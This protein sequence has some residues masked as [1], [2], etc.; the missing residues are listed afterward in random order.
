[1]GASFALNY[2]T[3]SSP[4]DSHFNSLPSYGNWRLDFTSHLTN[5]YTLRCKTSGEITGVRLALRKGVNEMHKV[6]DNDI[7][8]DDVKRLKSQTQELLSGIQNKECDLTLSDLQR[9]LW[10]C[11]GILVASNKP[12][13]ELLNYLVS[14]PCRI[15]TSESIKCGSQ[16]WNWLY[17]ERPDLQVK[18]IMKLCSEWEVSI[19]N[20]KGLF[21]PNFITEDTFNKEIEYSPSD[22]KLSDILISMAKRNFEPHLLM[23]K[24]FDGLLMSINSSNQSLIL[25]LIKL[26]YN[27]NQLHSQMSNHTLS[28]QVRFSLI[29]LGF[30]VLNLTDIDSLIDNK[31][32]YSLYQTSFTW[33]NVIPQLN[34]GND[35]VEIESDII[36]LQ[37]IISL[38]K[39]DKINNS[40]NKKFNY[41]EQLIEFKNKSG[42]LT[43]LLE[44]EISR[45]S[46]WKNVLGEPS[47]GN[48]LISLSERNMNESLWLTYIHLSWKISPKLAIGL[49][50]RFKSTMIEKEVKK[51]LKLRPFDAIDIP[52]AID[53]LIGDKLNKDSK[54]CLNL[55]SY[56]APTKPSTALM[57]FHPKYENNQYL[58]QYAMKTLEY[59]PVNLTFF[60]IPQIVQALRYD[61]YGYIEKFIFETAKVSQLFCHQIIW[62]MKANTYKDDNGE[63]PDSLKPTLE[64]MIDHIVFSLSGE[65]KS[66][67]ER[68]FSFFDS[69][70]SI[71]GK[72]KPYVKKTKPEKKA[73]IDE[74]MNK[75]EVDPGVYLPS[76]PDGVVVDIDKKAGR[77]LQSHAKAPFMA[78]FKVRKEKI[79]IEKEDDKILSENK[80]EKKVEYVDKWQAAIFKVGD[81]CRQDMLALQSIAI[82]K[83]IFSNIGLKLYLNPYRVTATGPGVSKF[84]FSI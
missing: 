13:F 48:D 42:L 17:F 4:L 19:F 9:L 66:F 30:K 74:E 80:E 44:N 33:F 54:H 69:I 51:L 12:D 67:Y 5:D 29:K 18:L 64:R 11:A 65:A 76:N 16:V 68:E 25:V 63:E 73:K 41:D 6:P 46:V 49:I 34:V 79:N 78:T 53:L 83:T 71:S 60:Y 20:K 59:H 61:K 2:L 58:L 82:F 77:P 15:F 36:L 43:L 72:L 8:K 31:F 35:K 70:T 37:S 84:L 14:V 40:S 21:S 22:E 28:R 56:W 38:I 27:T 62:N 52:E 23:I 50:N 7:A 47:K 1:M 3:N 57:F 39:N 75:I 32:R 24:F 81:D 26:I 55:L 10:R 45:L